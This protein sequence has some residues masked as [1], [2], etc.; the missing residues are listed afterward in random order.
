[1]RDVILYTFEIFLFANLH[2]FFSRRHCSTDEY[3]EKFMVPYKSLNWIVNFFRLSVTFYVKFQNLESKLVSMK[4]RICLMTIP[5]HYN[6]IWTHVNKDHGMS[7]FE[8]QVW[9]CVVIKKK[10]Y[11]IK[12]DSCLVGKVQASRVW[13]SCEPIISKWMWSGMG[14]KWWRKRPCNGDGAFR[15]KFSQTTN[16]W[17]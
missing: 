1:M 2:W 17:K 7:L 16:N 6:A 3:L 9:E 5:R 10:F 15:K 11:S 13:G 8:Y 4:C 12:R 14:L